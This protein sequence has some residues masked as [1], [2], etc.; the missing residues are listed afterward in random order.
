M[1]T[2]D[3]T[4]NSRIG[5]VSGCVS[6]WPGFFPASCEATISYQLAF[7]GNIERV[8]SQKLAGCP[9]A[10]AYRYLFLFYLYTHLG[11]PGKLV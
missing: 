9:D 1:V 8:E 6:S 5:A 2:G 11:L 3:L 10:I 4:D 7:V